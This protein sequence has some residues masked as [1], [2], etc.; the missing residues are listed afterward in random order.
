MG[1]AERAP[2]ARE[3]ARMAAIVERGMRAGAWGMSTGLIYLPGR[4]A[5]TAELIALSKV[6]A[7]HGGLYASHIRNEGDELLA[8]VE[9]ALKIGRDA[10]LP[11]HISHLKAS[12]KSSWGLTVPA[13]A[14]IAE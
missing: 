2:T 4:Y 11:A 13:C 7:R 10:G 9:E 6:V 5:E 14:R 3:L 8:S 12:G 1:K